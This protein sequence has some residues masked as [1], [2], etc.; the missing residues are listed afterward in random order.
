MSKTK[1]LAILA[2]MVG[3]LILGKNLP[4]VQS[5]I[6]EYKLVKISEAV[7]PKEGFILPIFW[8]DLGPRLLKFGVIDKQKFEQAINPT[9]DQKK[10]LEDGGDIPIKIHK[11][12]SRFVVDLLWAIGLAQKSIV[13]D[14]GPLG[15]E[16]KN[17][18]GN[19]ASTG[20]YTEAKG[21]SGKYFNK[22][23]L[24]SL[25]TGQQ[26]RVADIV[27]NIYRPCCDNPTWFPDCN[28]A[29]AAL[30]VVEMM[31]SKNFP[32]EEIYSS[33]L[34]L[35]SFWFPESYLKTAVYFD[36]QGIAWN[37]VDA[38]KVLGVD[39]SSYTGAKK[40]EALVGPIPNIETILGAPM[41]NG[42]RAS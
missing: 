10:I 40:I 30:A 32:D 28:H 18:Q 16:F 31:V 1:K 6:L 24:I 38:K 21:D 3:A 2:L 39:F 14:E 19:F 29:M 33:I 17:E 20:G 41:A 42:C 15:K 25:T 5:K 34:K 27:K 35:N 22:F 26:E 9:A 37:K 4:K 23:N 7:L 8:G 11:E 36:R 13:F 12:N